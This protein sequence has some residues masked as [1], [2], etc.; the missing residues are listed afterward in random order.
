MELCSG[1]ELLGFGTD[2]C[3]CHESQNRQNYQA[4]SLR[5]DMLSGL[6]ITATISEILALW[7][8][9]HS[10]P[11]YC[12]PHCPRSSHRCSGSY[13]SS[14][15][16]GGFILESGR[17]TEAQA[18]IVMRQARGPGLGK[19]VLEPRGGRGFN[20]IV[21]SL[22]FRE[23]YCVCYHYHCISAVAAIPGVAV[24]IEGPSGEVEQEVQVTEIDF[25][26]GT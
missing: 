18:V 2:Q 20:F 3:S 9:Y 4:G 7:R 25:S 22:V 19:D 11:H 21:E 15:H 23:R 13:H 12:Y 17:H 8:W 14:L 10:C 26:I 5:C 1:G 6:L 16:L 24:S